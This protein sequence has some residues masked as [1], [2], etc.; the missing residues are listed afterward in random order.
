MQ[1]KNFF[2][3]MERLSE[4]EKDL[5]EVYS[6]CLSFG[7]RGRYYHVED[8]EKL[9]EL[10]TENLLSY[11]EDDEDVSVPDVL[12][13][14]AYPEGEEKPRLRSRWINKIW[15]VGLILPPLIVGALFWAAKFYLENF[16]GSFFLNL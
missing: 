14:M 6:Y 15:F 16:K 3:R 1:E 5:R 9:Q 11:F 8:T 2:E 13:P 7:Y 10:K 4:E 12:C